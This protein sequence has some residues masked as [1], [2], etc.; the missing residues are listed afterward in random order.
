MA[1][2]VT[3]ILCQV[4]DI[5]CLRPNYSVPH[6]FDVPDLECGVLATRHNEPSRA[7]DADVDD[8]SIMFLKGTRQQI[9]LYT[10]LYLD[11]NHK[12]LQVKI[13]EVRVNGLM[14]S[15]NKPLPE[16]KVTPYPLTE[17][18]K[19]NV[20]V[21]IIPVDVLTKPVTTA[22]AG[23]KLT[24]PARYIMH[25]TWQSFCP[26][27]QRAYPFKIH[28]SLEVTRCAVSLFTNP[29]HTNCVALVQ[30]QHKSPINNS[31]YPL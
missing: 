2:I 10:L 14:P 9:N 29:H 17:S 11:G 12:K 24:R 28:G 13:Y 22:S 16:P 20:V 19:V 15:S 18:E 6:T 26:V 5:F 31:K 30:T 1:I 25:T 21:C 7:G 3:V 23:I 27:E 4:I 8:L